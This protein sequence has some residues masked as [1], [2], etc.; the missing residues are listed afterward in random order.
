MK[1]A[2]MLW[3]KRQ[4]VTRVNAMKLSGKA[5]PRARRAKP[6]CYPQVVNI[7]KEEVW[8]DRFK[9]SLDERAAGCPGMG[10]RGVWPDARVG[11]AVAGPTGGGGR[12]VGAATRGFPAAALRLG[13]IERSVSTDS[14]GRGH[15]GPPPAG[16]PRADAPTHD[17]PGAGPDY[18]R[19]HPVG[20]HRAR[21][22]A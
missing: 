9:E 14:Q 10:A 22:G 15:P 16:P 17:A 19:H 6:V 8:P 4:I 11:E 20:L 12:D 1:T 21:G 13:G 18:P 5:A 2:T 3:P 7:G